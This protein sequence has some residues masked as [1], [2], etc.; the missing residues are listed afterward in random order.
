[1][2]WFNAA[3]LKFTEVHLTILDTTYLHSAPVFVARSTMRCS[4]QVL[5]S[6]VHPSSCTQQ[7][8]ITSYL[9]SV[10]LTGSLSPVNPILESLQQQQAVGAVKTK[11]GFG[12]PRL[13]QFSLAQPHHV[14]AA[15]EYVQQ[16]QQ[17][18]LKRIMASCDLPNHVPISDRNVA[19]TMENKQQLDDLLRLMDQMEQPAYTLRQVTSLLWL[20]SNDEA[21]KAEWHRA[22]AEVSAAEAWQTS[23]PS[24]G[25]IHTQLRALLLHVREPNRSS[26][27]SSSWAAATLWLRKHEVRTGQRLLDDDG[28]DGN[29][30]HIYRVKEQA[31]EEELQSSYPVL[32]EALHEVEQSLLTTKSSIATPQT[33]ARMYNYIGIRTEQAKLLGYPTVAD[34]VLAG[35]AANLAEIR[36]LHVSMKERI[37]PLLRKLVGVKKTRNELAL[38]A[39]LSG[40]GGAS[41]SSS[42]VSRDGPEALHRRDKYMM[43]KLEHHVTL[44]GALQFVF[45]LVEDL[46]GVSFA[47]AEKNDAWNS[48]VQLYHAF[49]ETNSKEYLGSFYLD[50]F[51]REGKLARSATIPIFAR[52]PNRPPLVCLSIKIDA[53]AWDTDPP[54]VTW[55]DCESLFHEFGHVLQFLL[56]H[57]ESGVTMG[58]QNMPLDVSEFLPK[59]G[60]ERIFLWI[61][62]AATYFLD[63]FL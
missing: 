8:S 7:R 40:S 58:P 5:R 20:L 14:Q 38:D 9:R 27:T 36:R 44:D 21:T 19:T 1:M 28:D 62:L 51:Q 32:T 56:A 6:V 35:A 60:G 13:P 16:Q 33:I 4:G 55:E 49:D 54:V 10:F 46:L 29:K 43:L 30:R 47:L 42:K 50:P 18:T 45:R 31:G 24:A 34:Q 22:A 11:D 63:P 17:A 2:D 3:L 52:G 37:V 41:S 25:L 15:V 57:S 26:A 12:P 23:E 48:D 39:Y 53:P 61:M 59:V